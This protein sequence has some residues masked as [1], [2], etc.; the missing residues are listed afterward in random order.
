MVLICYL[1]WLLHFVQ[2]ASFFRRPCA[3]WSFSWSLCLDINIV[4]SCTL[5]SLRNNALYWNNFRLLLKLLKLV[6][7]GIW[8]TLVS[9]PFNCL[10]LLCLF[11]LPTTSFFCMWWSI[12]FMRAQLSA[13]LSNI[14][15]SIIFEIWKD[16]LEGWV[17][18]INFRLRLSW[19][20]LIAFVNWMGVPFGSLILHFM[21]VSQICGWLNCISLVCCLAFEDVHNL[22]MCCDGL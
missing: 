4:M 5:L 14:C 21:S 7:Y 15:S 22:F 16:D 18:L 6:S 2:A 13:W 8:K 12:G 3:F 11:L 9:L 19:L 10:L 20:Q 1:L 17:W